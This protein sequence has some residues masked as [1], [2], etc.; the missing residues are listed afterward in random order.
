MD[1]VK[2]QLTKDVAAL[3][4][5]VAALRE[6]LAAHTHVAPPVPAPSKQS[7]WAKRKK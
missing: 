5:Q 6:Q 2:E 7:V 3:T 4:Q 1:A